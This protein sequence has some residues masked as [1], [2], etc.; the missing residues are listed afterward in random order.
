MVTE[1][2]K[3]KVKLEQLIR[4]CGYE[5]EEHDGRLVG[6]QYPGLTVD[7]AKQVYQ[8]RERLESGDCINWVRSRYGWTFRQAVNFLQKWA[9][10]PSDLRPKVEPVQ[11]EKPDQAEAVTPEDISK[12]LLSFDWSE[13]RLGDIHELWIHHLPDVDLRRLL[14]ADRFALISERAAIP[15]LFANL[16]GVLE[17]EPCSYCS[18]PLTSGGNFANIYL[19]IDIGNDYEMTFPATI[20]INLWSGLYC[21]ACVA[22]LKLLRKLYSLIIK[23]LAAREEEGEAVSDRLE[24]EFQETIYEEV[25]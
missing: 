11:D 15:S 20:G 7:P 5:L 12:H 8:W 1:G 16:T 23:F 24:L 9:A 14:T 21:G 6:V 22:K 2:L 4:D 19:S 18:K 3:E 17:D 25:E 10:T 13:K